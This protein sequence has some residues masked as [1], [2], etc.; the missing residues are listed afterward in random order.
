MKAMNS[1][2]PNAKLKGS[3]VPSQATVAAPVKAG[4]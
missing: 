4:I 3:D 2:F 1:R